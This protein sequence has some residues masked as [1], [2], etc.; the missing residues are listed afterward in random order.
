[1][2]AGVPYAPIS[3][4]DSLLSQDHGKLRHIVGVL[5]PGM[6]FAADGDTFSKAIDAAFEHGLPSDTAVVLTTAA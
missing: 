2:L 3:A 4:A 1:M 5:T 6:V